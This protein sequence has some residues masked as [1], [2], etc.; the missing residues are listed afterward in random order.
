VA[1]YREEFP[2][3]RHTT[4]LNTCSLGA[5][6]LR[7]RRAVDS[8]LD[9]WERRGAAAWYDTWLPAVERLRAGYGRVVGAEARSISLHGCISS[10]LSVVAESLDYRARARVITTSLDFP[11]VAYQWLAKRAEGVELVV[12][13]SPD[14]TTVPLEALAAVVDERTALIATSHVFFTSGVIQNVRAVADLA[15]RHGALLLVDGYQ[16]TGQLPVDV[17]ALDVDFYCSGGLKWLLGGPGIAFLYVRKEL[18]DRLAPRITGWLGHAAPFRF[19]AGRLERATDA[20]RFDLGTPAMG[21][22]Y[23]QLAGLELLEEIGLSTVQ[24]LSAT[25]TKD[26][27]AR[28]QDRGLKPKVAAQAAE[29][30]SIVMLPREDP[31]GDVRRLAEAG[32]VVDARPGHVRVSP[33]FY[34]LPED[35]RAM[36]E[37][38]PR[39]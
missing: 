11:T 37:H 17:T 9:L 18:T 2:V 16:A 5:L 19:D 38:L 14:G 27:I 15:H 36:L 22:V 24:R 31:A 1:R 33:Y 13:E 3:F 23:A 8:Y 29:R 28:A 39:V 7:G 21:S 10:A 35:H 12:V 32:F 25:L 6:S 26:L 4:Y 34:N 30:S 20:R